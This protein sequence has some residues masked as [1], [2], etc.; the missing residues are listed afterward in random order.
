MSK[1]YISSMGVFLPGDAIPNDRI[2]AYLGLIGGQ[3]SRLK[4]RVIANSGIQTRHYAIDEQQ[5]TLYSNAQMA[6]RAVRH[7]L[8]K[9]NIDGQSVDF[10][11]A[12]TSQGDLPLPGFASMVHGE[13]GCCSCEI[14]SFQSVCASGVMAL[15]SALLHLVAG[16]KRT[17]I[18]CASEFASRLFKPSRYETQ[19]ARQN[20]IGFDTEFLRWILSDGAGAAVLTPEPG[21]VGLSFEV[22]WIELKSFANVF[23]PCM[24]VGPAKCNGAIKSWLDYPTFF[25]AVDSG[26]L[27]LRQDV[28][29][30]DDVVSCALDAAVDLVKF[31][32]LNPKEIDWIVVHYSSQAFQKKCIEAAG[33]RGICIPTER[34]FTN[35]YAKGNVGAASIFVLLEELLYSGKL[36]PGQHVFCI[37]PESGR[38]LFGYI[39]LRVAERRQK[40]VQ[41]ITRQSTQYI[42]PVLR[43]S[44]DPLVNSLKS[45]L[46]ELW[47][48]FEYRLR[49]VPIVAKLLAG[50]LTLEDYK[51]L[52]LNLRQQVIEGSRWI[53][54][55]ASN[56]SRDHFPL[57]SAF[58]THARDEHRDFELIEKDYASIG[59]DVEVIR[60]S[61]A[62]AGTEALSAYILHCGNQE[63]PFRLLGAMFIIEGLGQRIAGPWSVRIQEQLRL[64]EEAVSFFR[65]HSRVDVHHFGHLDLAMSCGILTEKLVENIVMCARVTAKLYCLQLEEIAIS[66][67]D[68]S[69]CPM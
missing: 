32:R 56:I 50:T 53:A 2:E 49:E 61:R 63:N 65:Y 45:Q 5:R 30:L 52:L 60:R 64:G 15:K 67:S 68:G 16:G 26:A 23:E 8:V 33:S 6:A 51:S 4:D 20:G 38:F 24:Y 58:L 12:A 41:N 25:E 28:R 19:H 37:I 55:A 57:R 14:A 22:E 3:R 7:A 69:P 47:C 17:A 1:A 27:N 36:Q 34:W 13:L 66:S 35:L 44:T 9:G 48:D 10:L 29:M 40:V 43:E 59:G 54:R 21:T 11:A 31:G 42:A 39:L 18:A 46:G 62:N